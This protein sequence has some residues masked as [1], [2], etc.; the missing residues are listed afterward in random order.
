[1][2][3]WIFLLVIAVLFVGF[4]F[5]LAMASPGIISLMISATQNMNNGEITSKAIGSMIGVTLFSILAI[6]AIFTFLVAGI[7][8]NT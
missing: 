4:V 6:F 5:V 8:K 7:V 1:M 3:K 2:I